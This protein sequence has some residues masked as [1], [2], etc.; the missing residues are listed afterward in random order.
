[1][2]TR[3][4]RKVVVS[5]LKALW[6]KQ[7]LT[8]AARHPN[9]ILLISFVSVILVILRFLISSEIKDNFHISPITTLIN[10]YGGR[11]W[12]L[13]ALMSVVL[14]GWMLI[15]R[16]PRLQVFPED[17]TRLWFYSAFDTVSVSFFS[18]I[19]LDTAFLAL[20]ATK[21]EAKFLEIVKDVVLIL[22]A[23]FFLVS[24]I[25]TSLRLS[26]Q[27]VVTHLGLTLEIRLAIA[28]SVFLLIFGLLL[29]F[30]SSQTRL[31]FLSLFALFLS[32]SFLLLP[33][34]VGNGI[35]LAMLVWHQIPQN[36][37]SILQHYDEQEIWLQ[38]IKGWLEPGEE[39]RGFTIGYVK[40][41][42][43]KKIEAVLALTD[44]Y[45]RIGTAKGG[46]NISLRDIQKIQWC[47]K[48]SQVKVFLVDSKSQLSLSVFGK[49]WKEYGKKLAE[50]WEQL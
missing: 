12:V 7:A 35:Y 33:I 6:K 47:E 20:D 43:F 50:S 44:K 13:Y 29:L 25:L 22:Y 31:P 23:M 9:S 26:R 4:E 10:N 41:T 48:R 27:P 14:Y 16:N 28:I 18:L 32:L 45:V 46:T 38:E 30:L 49:N 3:Q 5:N 36:N 24:L 37:R 39:I 8:L 17:W 34:G 11:I 40:A 1:M 19:A 2:E 21:S 15:S 42:W